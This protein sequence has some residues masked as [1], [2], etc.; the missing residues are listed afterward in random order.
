[1]RVRVPRCL[2][3]RRTAGA[4]AVLVGL[5]W[6]NL[7]VCG[8]APA[9]AAASAPTTTSPETERPADS[10]SGIAGAKRD[11]EA[12]KAA[13][14]PAQRGQRV[15]G[16]SMALPELSVAGSALEVRAAPSAGATTPQPV[17]RRGTNWLV[18]AMNREASTAAAASADRERNGRRGDGRSG[19]RS[20]ASADDAEKIDAFAFQSAAN[21]RG[22]EDLGA[23]ARSDRTEPR[24]ESERN[25]ATAAENPLDRYLGEWIAPRDYA[26]LRPTLEQGMAASARGA[27]AGEPGGLS[28]GIAAAAVGF[29]G[30][31]TTPDAVSRNLG[32][33]AGSRVNPYLESLTP[34]SD[35]PF[36]PAAVALPPPPPKMAATPAPAPIISPPAVGPPKPRIPD[37]ARPPQDEKHFKQ[38]KRF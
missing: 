1:M 21:P 8:Q 27:G 28:A 30:S 38:L 22:A 7:E 20:G 13:K 2:G 26:L 25:T 36:T 23:N 4:T 17:P 35:S 5:I 16:G 34:R 33:A 24:G 3:G 15:T 14:D 6:E 29:G 19:S 10:T 9:S 32:T 12:I 11:F 31:A 18:D 37:F